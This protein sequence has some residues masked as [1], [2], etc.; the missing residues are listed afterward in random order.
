MFTS[1]CVFSTCTWLLDEYIYMYIIRY[2]RTWQMDII[3]QGMYK[4]GIQCC[5]S[6]T[7][8]RTMLLYRTN[9]SIIVKFVGTPRVLVS[10]C[11][12]ML[13]VPCTCTYLHVQAG[14]E[15]QVLSITHNDTQTYLVNKSKI[16][17]HKHTHWSHIT[18]SM[19]TYR[20]LLKY[21]HEINT[22]RVADE[23][24]VS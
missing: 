17:R 14:L 10:K 20:Q 13:H 4:I 2:V 19:T 9:F 7:H 1:Q 15:Y 24:R 18:C 16:R 23:S 8:A 6:T 11:T 21:G 5:G 12:S 3:Y 22:L